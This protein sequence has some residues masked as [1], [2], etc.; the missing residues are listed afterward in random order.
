MKDLGIQKLS[1]K[2]LRANQGF[3]MILYGDSG[4][5]K[6]TSIGT[7]PVGKTFIVD[8]EGSLFVI[9]DRHHYYMS[10]EDWTD[11]EMA[12]LDGTYAMLKTEQ[13]TDAVDF[14][15]IKFV[16]IDTLTELYKWFQFY[17]LTKSNRKYFNKAIYGKAAQK[18][19]E[20]IRNYRNLVYQGKNV[21]F[22]CIETSMD[23]SSD[24]VSEH[25]KTYPY[26]SEGFVKEVSQLMDVVGHLEVKNTLNDTRQIRLK[27]NGVYYCKSRIKGLDEFESPD[28]KKLF[29]K[30]IKWQKGGDK[31]E[32]E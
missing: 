4:I 29:L 14:S 3:S 17:Y 19:R 8:V 11:D 5:G 28:L 25:K 2:K 23:L 7:L 27:D 16:V 30:M 26:L 13:K 6:T 18:L 9:E 15:K 24:G 12:K 32:A 31:N 1:G 22:T 20:Y 10:M 21:I